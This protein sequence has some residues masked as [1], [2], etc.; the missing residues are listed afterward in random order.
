MAER[1]LTFRHATSDDWAAIWPIVH[2][3]VAEGDT[4]A[5]P[6]DITERE[7]QTLWMFNGD[8]RRITYVAELDGTV[9]GTAY[10]KPNQIG[11]GD[12]VANAGWMI[13]P[14]ASGKGIGR[15]FAVHVIEEAKHLGF[16]G[17]QF[18]AVVSTNVRAI[19]LWESM[20]FEIVGTVP[21]AFRHTTEGPT[22]I[23][24]MHRSI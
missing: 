8:D 1:T 7:A 13:A 23:H 16:T 9:I 6:P 22:T 18:N 20:G 10:L 19:A 11:L 5:Y 4:Y 17:M 3:V 14:Q 2:E 24:I 15:R 21:K 12:H